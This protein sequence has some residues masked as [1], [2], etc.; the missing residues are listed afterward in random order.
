MATEAPEITKVTSER[1]P[2]DE[3]GGSQELDLKLVKETWS[4]SLQQIM[5]CHLIT[6]QPEDEQEDGP[7]LELKQVEE[8]GCI[9]YIYRSILPRF[10]QASVKK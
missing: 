10:I 4:T 6:W 7:V 2:E 3:Q 5:E 9:F 8:Q 1:Q